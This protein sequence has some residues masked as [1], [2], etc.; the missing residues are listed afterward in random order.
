MSNRLLDQT[1]PVSRFVLPS[2]LGSMA[3]LAAVPLVATGEVCCA[4]MLPVWSSSCNSFLTEM[5]GWLTLIWWSSA[6]SPSGPSPSAEEVLLTEG[7]RPAAE[8]DG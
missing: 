7:D 5:F 1:L 8:P 2:I 3:F 4:T 6:K